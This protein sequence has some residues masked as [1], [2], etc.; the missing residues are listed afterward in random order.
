MHYFWIERLTETCK[1][2]LLIFGW[3]AEIQ[4]GK[5]QAK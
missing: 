1:E 3:V 2:I 5:K 4:N